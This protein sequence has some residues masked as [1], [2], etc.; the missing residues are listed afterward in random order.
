MGLFWLFD[1]KG[2]CETSSF[3]DIGPQQVLRQLSPLPLVSHFTVGHWAATAP[4]NVTRLS[5]KVTNLSPPSYLS[6]KQLCM[7]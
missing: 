4:I 6:V 7:L 5:S 3:S 2:V 1:S